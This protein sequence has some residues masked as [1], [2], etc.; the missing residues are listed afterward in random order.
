MHVEWK[1]SMEPL[2]PWKMIFVSSF[3][4]LF[5]V[6]LTK[7]PNFICSVLVSLQLAAY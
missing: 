6:S 4:I 1:G 5:L 3:A 2:E 7:M